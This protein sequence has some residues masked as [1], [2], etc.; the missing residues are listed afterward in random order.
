MTARTNLERST[1]QRRSRKKKRG[2]F[3]AG[4]A[5]VAL[6]V[7]CFM[8]VTSLLETAAA[9]QHGQGHHAAAKSSDARPQGKTVYLTFDDGP[10]ELTGKLLDVLRQHGV[11]ATFFMQG[12]NLERRSWQSAVKR[13]VRE[14][15]Y[16]GGHSMTHQ[17][18]KL[19]EEGQFVPEMRET[20]SLIHDITGENPHLV[21]PP[22]GSAPGLENQQLRDQIA[23]DGI[24]IWDWTIDSNDW[25]LKDRPE[26]IVQNIKKATTDE[27]EVVLMHEKPQTLQVLPEIIAFYQQE[28]YSFGVYDDA[29]HFHLNFQKDHRL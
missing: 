8:K 5:A 24:K 9:K 2:R 23:D 20:L 14:G 16:V 26:Q 29:K 18:K 1:R 22:Y 19:Y 4:L 3:I 25:D 27:L 10:S 7:F 13:A 17:Y 12:T 6:L 21:R 11:K 28:G 15:H